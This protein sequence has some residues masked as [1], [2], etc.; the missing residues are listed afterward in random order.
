M[1]CVASC[2]EY[3]NVFSYPME[4]THHLFFLP[5][6]DPIVDEK[7]RFFDFLYMRVIQTSCFAANGICGIGRKV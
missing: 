2:G 6:T 5:L 3:I 4:K 1:V 7:M